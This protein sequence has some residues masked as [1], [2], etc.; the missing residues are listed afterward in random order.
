MFLFMRYTY[1][2]V[3]STTRDYASSYGVVFMEF[4]CIKD[5]I[6][7]V[8]CIYIYYKGSYAKRLYRMKWPK[9][10]PFMKVSTFIVYKGFIF[11]LLAFHYI[12]L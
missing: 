5:S 11:L 10:Y 2:F 7:S 12:F 3:L 6:E 1:W 9:V 4:V 8:Y